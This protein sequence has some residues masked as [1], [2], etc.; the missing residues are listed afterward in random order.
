MFFSDKVRTNPHHPDG[1]FWDIHLP[2]SNNVIKNAA[3]E[4]RKAIRKKVQDIRKGI[5]SY[6]LKRA[7][8]EKYL[9]KANKEAGGIWFEIG[10]CSPL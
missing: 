1:Y 3:P 2:Y 9:A 5:P 6:I 4:D 10:E 8:A 7:D